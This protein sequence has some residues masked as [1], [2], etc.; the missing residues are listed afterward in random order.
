M[1]NLI[2]L[3]AMCLTG[4]FTYAQNSKEPSYKV[5]GN[6]IQATLYHD[7]GVVA[8]TGF[9]T[10]EGKLQ[11]EWVSFDAMGNKTATAFYD[12]GNKVGTWTFYNGDEM[13]VVEYSD[14]K[15]SQVKTWKV[16]D[17]RVVSY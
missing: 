6:L 9:Y 17:T 2:V 5:N 1:K 16:T 12:N 8:Q 14:S 3:L 10:Q 11:G 13:N 15:I 4:V 7:N